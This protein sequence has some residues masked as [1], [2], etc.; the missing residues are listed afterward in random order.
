MLVAVPGVGRDERERDVLAVGRGRDLEPDLLPR[1]QRVDRLH[2][3]LR[4]AD[5]A[6]VADAGELPE[7]LLPGGD[8]GDE[9]GDVLRLRRSASGPGGRRGGATARGSVRLFQS[10]PRYLA[11]NPRSRATASTVFAARGQGLSLGDRRGEVFFQGQ[12]PAL[13]GVEDDALEV[14]LV[15]APEGR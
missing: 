4:A 6:D 8:L 13:V 12:A 2:P 15:A 14:D 5:L 1:D 9:R 3:G 10:V 11:F 7:P